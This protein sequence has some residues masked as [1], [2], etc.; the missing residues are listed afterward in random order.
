MKPAAILV[1]LF[2]GMAAAQPPKAAPK[3]PQ[4]AAPFDVTG[5][6]VSVVT[7]DW[8]WRMLTPAKG[9]YASVPLNPE[10]KKV[11]DT[12][13]PSKAASDGCKAYGAAGVMRVPGRLRIAWQ[14][15]STLKI[16]TDA[17]LQTRRLHF[18]KSP[19]PEEEHS[20]QGYSAAAW[21][22]IPQRG[23]LGVSLQQAPPKVGALKVITTNLRAGYLRTN[24]VPYSENTA[25]T[26]YFDRLSAYGIDWLTVLTIVEDAKYLDQPFITSTHF[27]READGSKWRP[28]PCEA[29]AGSTR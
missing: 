16:E 24:G 20:W 25:V 2:A 28:A 11:A 19:K 5:N 1:L 15:E 14:D 18:D 7:E 22:P 4:A 29:S 26:E 6:W 3:T 10:G 23:G 21:E 9:D 27:K 8:R 12:W 13:D 17:G